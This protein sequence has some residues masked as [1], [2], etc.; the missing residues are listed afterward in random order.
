VIDEDGPSA[1]DDPAHAAIEC[2]HL[3]R[4]LDHL[5]RAA[6]LIDDYGEGRAL[7]HRRQHRGVDGEMGN[8]G[9]LDLEQQGAEVLNDAREAGWLRRR[10]QSKLAPRSDDDIIGAAYQGRSPRGA[11]EQQ[12]AGCEPGVHLG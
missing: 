4:T 7:D 9:M 10:R 1:F 12:V 2:S 11:G 6:L 5:D 3:H 8:A